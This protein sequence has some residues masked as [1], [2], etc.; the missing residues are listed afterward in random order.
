M[1]GTHIRYINIIVLAQNI[2]IELPVFIWIVAVLATGFYDQAL[3]TVALLKMLKIAQALVFSIGWQKQVNTNTDP[4][5]ILLQPN[6]PFKST[7]KQNVKATLET[8]ASKHNRDLCS[9]S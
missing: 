1:N 4:I 3:P 2:V 5:I 7:N 8:C 6:M 9:I